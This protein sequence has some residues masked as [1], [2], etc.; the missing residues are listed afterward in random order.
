MPIIQ[1]IKSA[2]LKQDRMELT[3]QWLTDNNIKFSE[4]APYHLRISTPT[5]FIDVW[6]S[7]GKW[8]EQGQEV[9]KN[10]DELFVLL[11]KQ[12][13]KSTESP[14]ELSEKDRALLETYVEQMVLHWDEDFKIKVKYG[15]IKI[16]PISD[17]IFVVAH[18]GN[19]NPYNI[20]VAELK[21]NGGKDLDLIGTQI[22]LSDQKDQPDHKRLHFNT[23]GLQLCAV[24]NDV[25]K[26]L[27]ERKE[28]VWNNYNLRREKN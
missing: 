23:A 22:S 9:N 28:T 1:P 21:V 14:F 19:Y 18:F 25:T 24:A 15:T 10:I 27:Q 17:K 16:H 6:P 13:K 7:T 26:F 12:S 4:L 8:K 11:E 20:Y 3:K 5:T 2:K